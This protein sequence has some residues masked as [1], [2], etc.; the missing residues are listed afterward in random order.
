MGRKYI[1]GLAVV[2]AT[3]MLISVVDAASTHPD[4]FNA[5]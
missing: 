1:I 5:S 3:L 2:M 4:K